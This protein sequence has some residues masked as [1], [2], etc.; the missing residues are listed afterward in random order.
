MAGDL[1]RQVIMRSLSYKAVLFVAAVCVV[2]SLAT[3]SAKRDAFEQNER[4]GRGVNIIGYDPIWRSRERGRFKEKHFKL[5]KEAGFDSVR[6][7][8]HPFR[9]MDWEN[10]YK[11]KASW[12]ET[13]DWAVRNALAN[14][15]M[16]ILDMHEFN[17]IGRDPEGRKPALMSF[18]RQ[19]A[20]HYKDAPDNVIFEILNE[21]SQK[22]TAEMWNVWLNEALAIIRKT[23]PTRTVIIGPAFWSNVD[24]LKKLEL[25]QA[26][27][28]II[29][30]VH[31][32]KPMDF[33]HQGAS[34]AGR[35]DKLG[36]TWG[37]VEEKQAVVNNFE[38]VQAW[39]KKEKRPIFLGEFGAYDKAEM[40]YRIAYINHVTREAEKRNWSWAYWQFD[41]DFILYDI[42][43]DKWI[44]P[45]RD[46]LVPPE[47]K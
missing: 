30:T 29:V 3:V 7:N 5:I 11:L 38:K 26:D 20:E 22:L 41:S 25:P 15:L 14:D 17:A 39:A 44:E 1:E 2:L 27:R 13:C 9:H 12:F 4:L 19:V 28:N 35:K 37:T 42:P 43:N 16:V 8:L 32:Y 23:S 47:R 33:T 36:I 31:Y 21:P 18:W 10:D 34:W 46:A 24:Y 6:I 45:I 40:K